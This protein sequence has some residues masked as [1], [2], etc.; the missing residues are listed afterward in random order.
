[1]LFM[2]IGNDT[3]ATDTV[4]TYEIPSIVTFWF[5]TTAA[6]SQMLSVRPAQ[7]NYELEDAFFV[8]PFAFLDYGGGQLALLSRKSKDPRYTTTF[9]NGH[10]ID[11][12]LFGYV[13]CA[14]LSPHPI[15]NIDI[16]NHHLGSECVNIVSR[17]NQYSAPFSYVQ[18]TWGDFE[19]NVYNIGFT[20][21]I[22]NDLGFYLCGSYVETDG[23]RVN[24]RY[25]LGSL[26]SNVYYNTIVPM[27]LDIVYTSGEYGIHGS[28]WDSLRAAGANNF[29]DVS[30]VL[31][32]DSHRGS[33]YYTVNRNDYRGIG[34]DSLYEN[35]TR[36]YGADINNK[37]DIGE[38][39]LAYELMGVLSDV[40]SEFVG[41]HTLPSLNARFALLRSY[42]LVSFAL[43]ARTEWYDARELLYAPFVRAA[44]LLSD[45]ARLSAEVA[46]D[47]RHPS[48]V[49][50]YGPAGVS[51]LYDWTRGDSALAPEYVW[52]QEISFQW[53]RSFVTLYRHDY[54]NMIATYRDAGDTIVPQNVTSWQ[55]TGMEAH[56]TY[57]LPLAQDTSAKANTAVSAGVS[58]NYIFTGDSLLSSPKFHVR[59]FMAFIRETPRFGLGLIVRAEHVD[60]EQGSRDDDEQPFTVLSAIANLRFITLTFSIRVDNILDESFAYV[61]GYE[62]TQRNGRFSVTWEFWD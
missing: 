31:G 11:N 10:R 58:G 57:V 21:P 40:E 49:E 1:M 43:G 34:T 52:Q 39:V 46:R 36:N 45:S 15:E 33:L 38:Y 7:G 48:F 8:S 17:I 47:F 62:Y 54:T 35:I 60:P 44:F 24:S 37:N 18:F 51:H 16:S 3:T 61:N 26:Y 42:Q 5:R 55:R 12:P 9:L 19:T 23:Y 22:T 32:N 50:L 2:L 30:L 14:Q 27:R 25:D 59:G 13:N 6:Q 53:G 4:Q 20:R 29:T 28:A 56:I 41:E